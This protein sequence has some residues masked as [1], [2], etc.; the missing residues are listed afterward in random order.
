MP[1]RGMPGRGKKKEGSLDH[2]N[3][4]RELRT[5]ASRTAQPAG[6]PARVKKSRKKS[7][8]IDKQNIKKHV[9]E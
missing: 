1:I 7:V 6:Q 3:R 5:R 8:L 9:R 2:E 4:N